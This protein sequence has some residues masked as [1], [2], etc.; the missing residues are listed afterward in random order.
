MTSPLLLWMS[1]KNLG[2][3]KPTRPALAQE[4]Q[5]ECG[6]HSYCGLL[7]KCLSWMMNPQMVT[8]PWKLG[9]RTNESSSNVQLCGFF[10]ERLGVGGREGDG[11]E[12]REKKSDGI[13]S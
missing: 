10:G 1:G 5:G 11:N 6:S 12:I 9:E 7:A 3:L 13:E 8:W 4:E 2:A